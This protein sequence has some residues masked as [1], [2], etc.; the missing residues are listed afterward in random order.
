[1]YVTNLDRQLRRFPSR[2]QR[3]FWFLLA[4]YSKMG[5]QKT[6]RGKSYLRYLLESM[7]WRKG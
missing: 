6:D 5:E 3:S 7:L 2:L 4:A 1:M